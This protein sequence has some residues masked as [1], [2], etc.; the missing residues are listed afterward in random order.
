M[1]S[2]LRLQTLHFYIIWTFLFITRPQLPRRSTA[3]T[4]YV[5]RFYPGS[6]RREGRVSIV[7]VPIRMQPAIPLTSST[8]N[9]NIIH[10]TFHP[11]RKNVRTWFPKIVRETKAEVK[12]KGTTN[13]LT[14]LV[15]RKCDGVH[16]SFK[17]VG[18]ISQVFSLKYCQGNSVQ[19]W[20]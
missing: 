18:S 7:L 6:K 10:L 17:L 8:V 4:N 11:F 2:F 19:T 3:I 16:A 20:R 5:Q 14:W 1:F 9:W 12:W 13:A 15:I